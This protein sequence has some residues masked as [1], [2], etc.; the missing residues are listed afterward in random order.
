MQLTW[1]IADVEST[2]VDWDQVAPLKNR[3]P[4]EAEVGLSLARQNTPRLLG[5][6]VSVGQLTDAM[7][8]RSVDW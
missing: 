4:D 2:R 1:V 6:T 5:L 8:F 7:G 3:Y